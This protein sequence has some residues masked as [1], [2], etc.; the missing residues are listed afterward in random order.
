M[1][2]TSKKKRDYCREWRKRNPNKV[3][4]YRDRWNAK[5]PEKL[6][7]FQKSQIQKIKNWKYAD[8]GD[9]LKRI[10]YKPNKKLRNNGKVKLNESK[11][12]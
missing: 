8:P 6:K 10:G 4:N 5:H 1:F 9:V 12:I 2:K 7:E 11:G 3:K